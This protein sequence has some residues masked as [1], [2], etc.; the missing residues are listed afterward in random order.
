MYTFCYA[1]GLHEVWG[2]LWACLY[3][4]RMWKLWACSTSPYLSCLRTTM[5]VKNFWCQ[6]KHNYLHN[7]AWPWLDHLVWILIYKVAPSYYVR[8]NI[9]NDTYHMG[10]SKPL[11]TYQQAFK[12]SCNTLSKQSLGTQQ[13]T[14]NVNTWTCNCGSQ[15]YHCHHLC[16]HLVQAVH[17]PDMCF[18]CTIVWCQHS[19]IYQHPF[20]VKKKAP[21]GDTIT[22]GKY[23]NQM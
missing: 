19:S 10:C 4:P 21:D 5:D 18:F 9:L 7:V 11:T 12:K 2:Y 3:T 17:P 1:C 14:T 8:I 16:K 23:R 6:L 20:L 13:Y 15:M 22:L